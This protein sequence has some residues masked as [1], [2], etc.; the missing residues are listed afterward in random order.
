MSHLMVSAGT[1]LASLSR[2]TLPRQRS[3]TELTMAQ[4]SMTLRRRLH[5][6]IKDS[7]HKPSSHPPAL[8]HNHPPSSTSNSQAHSSF[9]SHNFSPL[10][11]PHQ[12]AA[13][14][15]ATRDQNPNSNS[16]HRKRTLRP[17]DAVDLS[18]SRDMSCRTRRKVT[19][20]RPMVL[21]CCKCWS[22]TIQGVGICRSEP[23]GLG[24]WGFT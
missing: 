2:H 6:E 8:D 11:P 5:L 4:W 1:A 24:D 13:H 3:I 21:G 16:P 17:P 12:T 18:G 22:E 20:S 19:G 23:G 14:H 10:P 15:H 7:N 9:L